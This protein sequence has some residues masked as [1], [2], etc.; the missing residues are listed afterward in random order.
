[1]T[2]EQIR[3]LKIQQAIL[4]ASDPIDLL[5]LKSIIAAFLHECTGATTHEA[6]LEYHAG[7]LEPDGINAPFDTNEPPNLPGWPWHEIESRH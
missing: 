2:S 3:R 5:T 4:H 1:M 7:Q 6:Y